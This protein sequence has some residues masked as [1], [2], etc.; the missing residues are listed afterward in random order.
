MSISNQMVARFYS[1]FNSDNS[2]IY[3]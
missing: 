3:K 1:H 2:T